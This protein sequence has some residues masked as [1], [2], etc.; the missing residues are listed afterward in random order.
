MAFLTIRLKGIEGYTRVALG[1]ERC[2]V[3]RSSSCD[4]PIAHSSISR[5]HCALIKRGDGWVVEDIGSANGTWLGK[6]KLVGA[7]PLAE[8]SIIKIGKARLTFH[9]GDLATAEAEAAAVAADAEG[10]DDPAEA[11]L[12]GDP[13]Q[14]HRCAGC[15]M[16]LSTV[17]RGSR[18]AWDCPRC[19]RSQ[20]A[21]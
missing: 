6:D 3:G 14:A 4:V 9:A 16:W 11:R 5:E 8:K 1:K 20:H 10:D 7:M 19:G 13:R 21:A 15:G 17:H 12:P 2:V 18:D